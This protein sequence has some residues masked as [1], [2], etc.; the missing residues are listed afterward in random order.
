[1]HDCIALF[2]GSNEIYKKQIAEHPGTYYLTSGWIEKGE[3]LL[4][5]YQ[6]YSRS[7]GPQEALGILREEMKNYT[8]LALIDTDMAE[9]DSDRKIALQ[10]AS[11]LALQYEEI[12]GSI[13]FF[14]N[15]LLG[16]WTDNFIVL[17][18]GQVLSQ[19]MFFPLGEA[20]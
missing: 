19:E 11:L 15:L 14:K 1:V 7:Y 17:T 10:N 2:L 16:P 20:P 12:K 6:D 5:K 18:E 9:A 13:S 8:R 3:T 4:S